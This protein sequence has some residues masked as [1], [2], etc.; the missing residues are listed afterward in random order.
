MAQFGLVRQPNRLPAS[1]YDALLEF[2]YLAPV[3]IIRFAIDGSIDMAN[4]EAARLL[5]PLSP[6]AE[7]SNMYTL[8][9]RVVPDLPA[10]VARF[11]ASFG[12][13]CSQ[14][15]MQVPGIPTV[16]TL[17]VTKIDDDTL[18]AVVQDI[19]QTVEI[20]AREFHDR[21]KLEAIYAHVED[22]AIC[23][24]DLHGRIVD[25]N[26]SLR[27]LGGWEEQDVVQKSLSLLLPFDDAGESR[28][29]AFLDRACQHGTASLE[30][31]VARKD[32]TRFSA[33]TVATALPDG[34]GH[35]M[36]FVL[37]THDLT[38]RQHMNEMRRLAST[39]LL[40]AA[41]NRHAGTARLEAAFS[42]L[43][44][45][46]RHFSL[47][48][49]DIDHFKRL[50]DLW[51]H[52]CGDHVLIATTRIMRETLREQD[53]IIRWGGEEFILVLPDTKLA[54][55][56]PIAN[57]VRAAVEAGGITF[58]GAALSVT[59][60]V[61]VCEARAEDGTITEV[62][63]VADSALYEAKRTGRN[64]VVAHRREREATD[65]LF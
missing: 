54:A 51:G 32:G 13:V 25:W 50:N 41:L 17:S 40:T 61:G 53:S 20:K 44:Q 12:Q 47:V 21:G 55:A 52:D 4:A 27:R 15:R 45:N 63:R 34:D 58:A 16:L 64:R 37:V 29:M 31:W 30:C 60:S 26:T 6:D 35:A 33:S 19:T 49:A 7:L 9:S 48:M 59:V 3:A 38:G 11:S 8:L 22:Y 1:A 24:V 57:R 39:D 56:V 14:V 2:L 23:R 36:G 65:V 43:Q 18:M 28:M 5:M 42:M 46:G 62:I 10:R